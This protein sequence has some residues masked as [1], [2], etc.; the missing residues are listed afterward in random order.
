VYQ[1]VEGAFGADVDYAQL[2]KLYGE[3]ANTGPERKYSPGVC[4]GA[5]KD[6]IEGN[7]ES[8]FRFDLA[9]RA[10]EPIHADLHAAV[11]AP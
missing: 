1:L 4:I 2:V 6:R 8:R 5:R 11:H 9:C 10:V 3:S 7:P